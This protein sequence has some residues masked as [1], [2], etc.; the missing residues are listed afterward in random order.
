MKDNTSTLE[1]I[2]Y[3]YNDAQNHI[4]LKSLRKIPIFNTSFLIDN[5]ISNSP[6]SESR[7]DY[8]ICA[9][10]TK[11]ITVKCNLFDPPKEYNAY[12]CLCSY[13]SSG[14]TVMLILSDIS[15][16]IDLKASKIS[17]K[18]KTVMF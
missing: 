3:S 6:K 13:F 5:E 9:S 8:R 16:R 2:L 14:K 15:D 1:D 17:E 11:E 10:Q 4:S 7:G 12:I 18:M